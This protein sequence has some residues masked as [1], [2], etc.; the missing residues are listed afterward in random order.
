MIKVD[1]KDII[2]HSYYKSYTLIFLFTKDL[3]NVYLA[4]KIKGPCPNKLN[5]IGGKVE[6]NESYFNCAIRECKEEVGLDLTDTLSFISIEE[7][8]TSEMA[9]FTAIVDKND[10]KPMEDE[11]ICWHSVKTVMAMPNNK[12]ADELTRYLNKAL[13][14]LKI[15]K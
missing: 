5:A 11:V 9:I 1:P 14:W 7:L 6:Q 12:L 8:P 10:P 13:C 4:Y 3:K 15:F 2:P